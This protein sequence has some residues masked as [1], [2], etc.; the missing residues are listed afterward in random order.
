MSEHRATATWDY[1]NKV[2]LVVGGT[3]GI[4]L[5]IAD[6]LLVSGAKLAVAARGEEGLSAFNS[7][8]N[9]SAVCIKT[10]IT[11]ADQVE[12]MVRRTVDTFGRLDV[13]F[14]VAAN[15]RLNQ[16]VD[17]SEEDWDAVQ[18]GVLRSTFV[19]LKHEAAQMIK[20]GT[21][22]AIVNVT[23]VSA[24]IPGRGASAYSSAKAG[25]EALTRVAALELASNSIRVNALSPG[26][27][28][29]PFTKELLSIPGVL[30]A[31]NSRIAQE[32]PADPS[33]LAG[34]AL[35]LGSDEATYITGATLIVDG[36]WSITGYPDMRPFFRSAE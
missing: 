15:I 18:A 24:Q 9:N 26:L 12:Q 32:R 30:E 17:L 2:A 1:S 31:Y 34:P 13:A 27:V 14:N 25:A 36:G 21:G 20:Q 6:R 35:F 5:A 19:C 11:H 4:G 33:E 23:S 29:T 10:D 7:R 22:G 28:A 3:A 16:I 8:S